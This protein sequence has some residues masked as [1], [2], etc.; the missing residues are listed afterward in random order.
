MYNKVRYREMP[1]EKLPDPVS[2]KI[3][4]MSDEVYFKQIGF[5]SRSHQFYRAVQGELHRHLLTKVKKKI[6][7]MKT[8][9]ML[10]R[11]WYCQ[12]QFN[13]HFMYA[14]R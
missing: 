3:F 7:Y 8:N 5:T 6:K 1:P 9:K 11:R 13:T 2:N 14:I 10:N 12:Q 4:S